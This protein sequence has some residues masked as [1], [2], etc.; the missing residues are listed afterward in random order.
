MRLRLTKRAGRV[1]AYEPGM[2]PCPADLGEELEAFGGSLPDT[3][4]GASCNPHAPAEIVVKNGPTRAV[5]HNG[6]LERIPAP[7]FEKRC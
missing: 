4:A 3:K 2:R 7:V 5:W 1:Y 6:Q